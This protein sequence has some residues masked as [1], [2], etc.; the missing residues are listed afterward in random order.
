MV[1]NKEIYETIKKAQE[2]TMTDY[3][4]EIYWKNKEELD[5]YIDEEILISI[6]K[7]LIY[8]VGCKEEEIEDI[9]RNLEDNY[10]PISISSQVEITD[11]DFI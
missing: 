8:E 6:I 10:V 3:C 9:K 2:I 1:I 11:R 5:G 7:D 4:S